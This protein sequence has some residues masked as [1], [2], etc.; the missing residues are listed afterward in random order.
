MDFIIIINI[1]ITMCKS[2]LFNLQMH[3]IAWIIILL[4]L[5]HGMLYMLRIQMYV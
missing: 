1:I 5:L 3:R 4:L 2:D